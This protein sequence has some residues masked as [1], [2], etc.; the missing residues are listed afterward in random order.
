MDCYYAF[1]EIYQNQIVSGT[2]DISKIKVLRA[3]Y[4]TLPQIL[5][6]F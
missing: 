6:E 2:I 5:L 4:K 3:G 1:G